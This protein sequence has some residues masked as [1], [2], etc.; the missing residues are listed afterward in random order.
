VFCLILEIGA[1]NNTCCGHLSSMGFAQTPV[2]DK[3]KI[4][5][6]L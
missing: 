3:I 5:N 1:P 2:I 6:I 4:N